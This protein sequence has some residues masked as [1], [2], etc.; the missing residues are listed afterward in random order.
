[1][2]EEH[3]FFYVGNLCLEG[4]YASG[5]G[6]RG[7]VISH[8]H[9]L[10]GGSMRNNVVEV[11]ASTFYEKGYSTLRFNFR[12]VGQSEGA[13]DEGRGEQE[14]VIGAIDFLKEREKK[15][16]ILAGYSF[17]AWVNL[18]V[19]AHHA[20]FSDVILVSPPINLRDFDFSELPEN[21]G[22]IISGDRDQFCSTERLQTLANRINCRLGI[23]KGADHFYFGKEN[24]IIDCLREYLLKKKNYLIL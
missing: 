22:L 7:V 19:L 6:S 1:M 18:K 4:L 23:V 20:S 8:P 11:L 16:V 10:M 9:P 2:R 15:D 14:D 5:D 17:G 13:Y 24:G 3:V 12:G 21:I